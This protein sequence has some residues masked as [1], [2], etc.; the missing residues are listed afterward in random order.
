MSGAFNAESLSGID[1]A[2]FAPPQI[3][4]PAKGV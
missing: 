4:N 2:R 1:L 3:Y